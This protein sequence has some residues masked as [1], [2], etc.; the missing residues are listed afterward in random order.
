MIIAKQ[1]KKENIAEYILY[2]WQIEDMIRSF[3]LNLNTI[4]EK[5]INQFQFTSEAERQEMFD[6]YKGLIEQ[7]KEEKIVKNGHLQFLKN[8]INDLYDLHLYMIEK[9]NAQYLQ[10]YSWA[11]THLEKL[12]EL[13]KN[14]TENEIEAGLNGLYG[15]L[16]LKLQKR[17]VSKETQESIQAISQMMAQLSNTHLKIESGDMELK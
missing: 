6:W 17:E 15:Y 8:T 12:Q 10:F 16:M 9:K 11:K 2:M 14:S 7:M 1:K 13:S 3:S 5:I 4:E